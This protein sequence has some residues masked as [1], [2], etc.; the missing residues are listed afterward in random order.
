[1]MEA[2]YPN[3]NITELYSII[4]NGTDEEADAARLKI[5]FLIEGK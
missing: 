1:M 4:K 2:R 3:T 5:Q